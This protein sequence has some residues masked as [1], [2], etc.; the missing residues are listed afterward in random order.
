M[1]GRVNAFIHGITLKF[2]VSSDSCPAVASW[3]TTNK[4]GEP[5]GPQHH[6]HRNKTR[7]GDFRQNF[8]PKE[9]ANESA[10]IKRFPS[11]HGD[12]YRGDMDAKRVWAEINLDAL[13]HNLVCIR[14]AAGAGVRIML[15]VKADA[16]G[17][18]SVGIAHHAVRSGIGALGVGTSAEALELRHAGIRVPILVLGTVVDEEL[19][20]CL[21]YDIHLGLHTGDRAHTLAELA[22][23]MGRIAKVHLNVDTGMGRLGVPPKRA[24]GL[25]QEVH[26]NPHL[27]LAGVMT[28]LAAT[29][30]AHDPFGQLQSAVF[31]RFLAAARTITQDLGWIH[32][33]N[34]AGIFTGLGNR[35]DTVRP[36]LA[37][38]G[39]L[40][41]SIATQTPLL[42]VMGLRSQIVFLKDLA[43]G[44][45]VGYA[46]TWRATSS[47]RIATLPIGYADG[48]PWRSADGGEV[49]IRGQRAPIVGR[50]SMDYTT[51][52]VGHIRDL[53]VGDQVTLIGQDG[54]E[55]ISL[56][57]L[58]QEAGTIPY[59]ISC[60]IGR[61]VSH[62]FTG[63]EHVHVPRQAAPLPAP[64]PSPC[65]NPA[66]TRS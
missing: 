21:G 29:D 64:M 10:G 28:H 9:R 39:V 47:T 6:Q 43:A 26:D 48:L 49:L 51:V 8:S 61:R 59:E 4:H 2:S 25:L 33:A 24:L 38:Y 14:K 23:R 3:T 35:Y 63:G 32:L 22:E 62:R 16:Y 13:G 15:V 20:D 46:S 55:R 30:G 54:K 42:P 45:P 37:A 50:V 65:S 44:T 56:S 19:S 7:I 1:N 18:G 17:H 5:I 66:P 12:R 41:D 57:D 36:G 34:S 40:P 53:Q 27:Q 11:T 60:S 31:D 58:A 52:D